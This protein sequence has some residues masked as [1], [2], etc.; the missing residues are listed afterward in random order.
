MAKKKINLPIAIPVKPLKRKILAHFDWFIK[1]LLRDKAN[2]V[3]LEGFLSELLKQDVLIQEILESEANQKEERQKFNRV[4][5]LVKNKKGEF[6]IIELQNDKELDFFHRMLFGTSTV[7]TERL[8]LGEP[9]SKIKKVYFIGIVYFELG[10][11]KDYV[12]HGTTRFIGIHQKDVLSL[13][14]EQK[15]QFYKDYPHELLPEYYVIRANNY[16]ESLVGDSLDEWV[17]FLKT[18]AVREDF[19]AKGIKE[20]KERL[21]IANMDEDESASYKAY[22]KDGHLAASLIWSATAEADRMAAKYKK[23]VA[24]ANQKIA[25]ANQKIAETNKKIENAAI[26]LLKMNNSPA[27]VASILGLSEAEVIKIQQKLDN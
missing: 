19:K 1:H 25:K 22:V 8:K 12:Y 17:Y 4:D 20:A 26:V 18:S 14:T 9:Y 3:I 13:T 2:Y 10:Q 15:A 7:V 23:Q 16:D 27:L 24:A 11:G 21:D 6:F 5:L